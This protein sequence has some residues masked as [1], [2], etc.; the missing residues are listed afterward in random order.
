MATETPPPETIDLNKFLAADLPDL[1]R[2]L[3][4]AKAT[5]AYRTKRALLGAAAGPPPAILRGAPIKT[6]EEKAEERA[7]YIDSINTLNTSIASLGE[8]SLES[9]GKVAEAQAEYFKTT[10]DLIR[11]EITAQGGVEKAK[12]AGAMDIFNTSMQSYVTIEQSFDVNYNKAA[13]EKWK[14]ITV[15]LPQDPDSW[16]NPDRQRSVITAVGAALNGL[17]PDDAYTVLLAVNDHFMD[18]GLP[19]TAFK[20]AV[21]G[22]IREAGEGEGG[23]TPA[24]HTRILDLVNDAEAAGASKKAQAAKYFAEGEQLHQWAKQRG[25]GG[26]AAKTI[27]AWDQ[28]K[29]AGLF[30]SGD[31]HEG[32]IETAGKVPEDILNPLLDQLKAM[33]ERLEKLDDPNPP[34]ELVQQRDK[35]LASPNYQAFKAQIA[36][37]EE[38]GAALPDSVVL[39]EY[40]KEGR[41]FARRSQ[42]QIKRAIVR[43]EKIPA[44]LQAGYEAAGG[45]P[46]PPPQPQVALTG[47]AIEALDAVTGHGDQVPATAKAKVYPD[48]AEEAAELKDKVEKPPEPAPDAVTAAAAPPKETAGAQTVVAGAEE[49]IDKEPADELADITAHLTEQRRIGSKK[50]QEE[51]RKKTPGTTLSGYFA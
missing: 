4:L 49:A 22:I 40:L 23:F 44:H 8:K 10:V 47:E 26:S 25:V 20:D 19:P 51:T 15:S 16:E 45:S 24:E 9:R 34:P 36:G 6:R 18:L 11:N 13:F 28:F 29:K 31:T 2:Y 43:G 27:Q 32:M 14:G 33:E 38:G 17:P 46:Q 50:R 5:R 39:R 12:I 37:S 35:I 41:S 3:T 42:H 21:G 1:D 30:P 48:Q 7:L